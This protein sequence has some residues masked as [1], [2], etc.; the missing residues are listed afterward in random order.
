ML[1]GVY[2]INSVDSDVKKMSP[3]NLNEPIPMPP[4]VATTLMQLQSSHTSHNHTGPTGQPQQGLN[5]LNP[6][7]AG[8]L[9][10]TIQQPTSVIN[11]SNSNDVVIGPMTQYQ[12]AVTIYQ[13]MD[14]TVP[15]TEIRGPNNKKFGNQYN[16][17]DEKYRKQN[18]KSLIQIYFKFSV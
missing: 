18:I 11:L 14:A 3:F 13:Y 1:F 5:D 8:R 6:L 2:W 9:N 16:Q 17:R 7:N 15:N 10:E 4:P 12:G